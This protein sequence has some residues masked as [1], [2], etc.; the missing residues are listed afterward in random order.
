M[1]T[2]FPLRNEDKIAFVNIKGFS[3]EDRI[4]TDML[5]ALIT[6]R[7]ASG[8]NGD[9]EDAHDLPHPLPRQSLAV[10]FVVSAKEFYNSQTGFKRHIRTCA[11]LREVIQRHGR[12]CFPF[13]MFYMQQLFYNT[14]Q[15][16][17]RVFHPSG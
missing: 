12:L 9:P 17:P 5:D 2:D 13:L 15:W 1:I 14:T 7:L 4:D 11:N 10:L 8:A 6:A 16:P 3:G